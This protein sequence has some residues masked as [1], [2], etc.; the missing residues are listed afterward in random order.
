L[1]IIY[2]FEYFFIYRYSIQSLDSDYRTLYL[3]S[4]NRQ[5]IKSD[6]TEGLYLKGQLKAQEVQTHE[7]KQN[8][9][10]GNE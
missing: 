7:T 4:W 1:Q 6:I 2:S 8:S 9:L 5:K 3:R 10:D